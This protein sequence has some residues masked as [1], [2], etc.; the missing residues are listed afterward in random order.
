MKKRTLKRILWTVLSLIALGIIG[1][2]LF[3]FSVKWGFFGPLPDKDDLS[4]I[5]NATATLVYS[6]DDQLIGKVFSENRTNVDLRDLPKHLLDA[7]V[8]T[9]DARFYEH[10]GVDKRSVLRVIVKSILLGDESS[11]GGSTITQ[12][13]AKNLYGRK[14]F[15]VLTLPV[16]K[17]KEII[18]AD[19]LE[20][21]YTKEQ[22][23]EFYLN[24]VPF[25]EDTYGIEAASL[26]FFAKKPIDLHPEESAVLIGMLKAGTI[27]NPRLHPERATQRRNVVLHQMGK[28]GYLQ[29]EVEDSLQA[30]PLKLRY[31]KIAADSYAPYFMGHIRTKAEELLEEKATSEGETYNLETDG[32]RIYTTLNFEMQRAADTAMAEHMQKLQ[33]L[34]DR[35]WQGRKPWGQNEAVFRSALNRSLHW[36]ALQ[37]KKLSDDSLK[38]YLDRPHPVQVYAA[39]G[40]TVLEMSLRDSVEYYISLLNCGFLAMQPEDG[41]IL[42]WSGGLNHRFLPYDHVLAERQAAST[43]KPIVYA[44]ALSNGADPCSYISNE[45][46]VY[47]S[48]ENWAPRNYDNEYGGFYSMKGALTKSINVAAVQT[49]FEAG[50]NEVLL[51]AQRMGITGDLP[52]DPSVALGT[53]SVSLY[54][55]VKA[56]AVFANGGYKVEPFY[57]TKIEDA[58]G[59]V[60]YEHKPEKEQTRILDEDVAA[61]INDMLQA[62]VNNG[63]GTRLRKVY[64]LPNS[65]AGKTGT[66]QNYTDG[67]FIGYN[68]KLVA[69]VWVGASSPA[70]HFR[71]G[72]YG[73]GSAM[74][75]PVFGEFFQEINRSSDLR[76][77]TSS[78]FEELEP[79]LQRKMN[80][81]DFREENLLDSFRGIFN[82][83]KGKQIDGDAGDEP[84]KKEKKGFFKRVFGKK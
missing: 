76:A 20:E 84:E 67:W 66:A 12:Q 40:D 19:R 18:L 77:Y 25:S 29:V 35:H 26:R 48:Y 8:A 6:S 65:L 55:M 10:E 45:R 22:I 13:L 39:G 75:L 81:D 59:E 27:Y 54:D 69:G 82:K 63:T 1:I 70:V 58:A 51:M 80:C 14:N 2:V 49:V 57:I 37:R 61:M 44:T 50:I 62:V 34:F 21:L 24:T 33:K 36:Q 53:G 64:G 15:S 38:Y 73:S 68:P 7:L 72:T 43:F 3:F 11:G 28:Y 56:Y 71:S 17:F 79:R 5:R 23:L 32:L 30:L 78:S 41:A 16:N 31:S 83:E 42:A 9:E 47:E 46:R 60:L 74:A 4:D 52:D